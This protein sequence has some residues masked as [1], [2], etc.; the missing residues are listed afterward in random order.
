MLTAPG[1]AGETARVRRLLPLLVMVALTAAPAAAQDDDDAPPLGIA[2]RPVEHRT[3]ERAEDARPSDDTSSSETSR[4]GGGSPPTA[5]DDTGPDHGAQEPTSAP[6][7]GRPAPV[8]NDSPPEEGTPPAT[9][10]HDAAPDPSA[11]GSNTAAETAAGHDAAPNASATGP[12]SAADTTA[13][14]ARAEREADENAT[15]AAG[16]DE[17]LRAMDAEAPAFEEELDEDGDETPPAPHWT[18]DRTIAWITFVSSLA[19]SIGGGVT[20]A[21]GIDQVNTIENAADG[22]MWSDVAGAR[23]FG[24]DPD[25]PGRRDP[26]ARRRGVDHRHR[27]AGPPRTGGHLARSQRP[28][29][30]RDGARRVLS[31]PARSAPRH[32]RQDAGPPGSIVPG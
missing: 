27:A 21:I 18:E 2:T 13:A 8:A 31:E 17:P 28:A 6:G 16:E 19:V 11:T 15:E 10:G 23:D 24:T 9:A 22:T 5:S 32:P 4:T 12:S 7:P 3:P 30:R 1:R 26:G 20:L 14:G 29:L 25:R